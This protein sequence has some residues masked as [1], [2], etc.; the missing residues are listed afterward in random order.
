MLVLGFT[1]CNKNDI[2]ITNDHNLDLK[3]RGTIAEEYVYHGVHYVLYFNDDDTSSTPNNTSTADSLINA[4]GSNPYILAYYEDYPDITY[5]EDL[6]SNTDPDTTLAQF[7]PNS[8]MFAE[9]FEHTNFQ[10]SSFC[11]DNYFNVHDGLEVMGQI[12]SEIFAETNLANRPYSL[13]QS[14]NDRISSFKMYR[15]G[16]SKTWYDNNGY[17]GNGTQVSFVL[18]RSA[19][20]SNG[21]CEY[22][23]WK[24]NLPGPGT[25]EG[26]WT[27][28][29]LKKERWGWICADLNDKV[30]SI[31]LIP[32]KCTIC[33][34]P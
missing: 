11:V 23:Q 3:K 16:A 33:I 19:G 7:S 12:C 28:S 9:F 10:G 32:C 17:S 15:D 34:A 8:C 5:V 25:T 26:P 27:V 13:S 14:W 6:P 31:S 21:G 4:I 24:M 2:G 20:L 1:A 29:N 30:S 18:Y 22:K